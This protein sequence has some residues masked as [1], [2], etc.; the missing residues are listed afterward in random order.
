MKIRRMAR[1]LVAAA[2]GFCMSSC[3]LLFQG[4]KQQIE[5]TS[6]P[7]GATVSI[8]NEDT[9]V[10]PFTMTVP[11]DQNLQ[12]HF[13][14]P[15]YQSADLVDSTRVEAL[16]M[17]DVIPAMLPWMVDVLAGAGFEHQRD[18]IHA[19]LEPLRTANSEIKSEVPPPAQADSGAADT[20]KL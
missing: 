18:S 2:S 20:G 16:M 15:G 17:V 5:V 11:R 14:K 10:T 12:L 4:I 9:K 6:D 13:S 8:N 19:Q 1:A 3:L 7:P